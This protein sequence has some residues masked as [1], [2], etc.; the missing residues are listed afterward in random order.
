MKIVKFKLI[1]RKALLT[2]PLYVLI[3]DQTASCFHI[4]FHLAF[5][6]IAAA[7]GFFPG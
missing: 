2:G 4:Q 7:S 1:L 3:H 6:G 5:V